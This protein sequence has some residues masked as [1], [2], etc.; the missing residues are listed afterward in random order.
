MLDAGMNVARLNFS[1]E[2]L[3]YH[4]ESLHNLRKALQQR[5]DLRCAVL[6]DTKGCFISFLVSAVHLE[7]GRDQS[8]S[9][10]NRLHGFRKWTK[11]SPRMVSCTCNIT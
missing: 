10:F 1:H 2:T 6:M 4:I 9:H 11:R 5:P 8:P 7:D 3:E